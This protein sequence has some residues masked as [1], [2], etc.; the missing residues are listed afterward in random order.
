MTTRHS[1]M[2]KLDNLISDLHDDNQSYISREP[3]EN[4]E[5]VNISNTQGN[6]QPVIQ[7]PDAQTNYSESNWEEGVI[8]NTNNWNENLEKILVSYGEKAQAYVWMHIESYSYYNTISNLIQILI[9]VLSTILSAETI[10]PTA[11]ITYWQ[12]ETYNLTIMLI[13]NII[14]YIITILSILQNF[15]KFEQV[16]NNHK[17]A[18]STFMQL[19]S[20]ISHTLCLK[21]AD[22]PSGANYVAQKIKKYD[23]LVMTSPNIPN[24]I[25]NRFKKVFK[26]TTTSVP[27]IADNL[28]NIEVQDKSIIASIKQSNLQNIRSLTSI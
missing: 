6:L 2:V 28:Q 16:K 15:F 7:T 27:L 12:V 3:T 23:E 11:L 25:I 21:R 17:T 19:S 22:R 1:T 24:H 4:I 13:K 20:D 14:T 10:L 26:N 5:M 8:I 18:L 9:L